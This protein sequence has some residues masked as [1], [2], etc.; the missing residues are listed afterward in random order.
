M[1]KNNMQTK[2]SLSW[3]STSEENGLHRMPGLVLSG[4]KSFSK[5]V[6]FLPFGKI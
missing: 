4:T 6:S 2:V 1:S 5:R 3:F